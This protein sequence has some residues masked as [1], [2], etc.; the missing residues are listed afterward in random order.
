MAFSETLTNTVING[1]RQLHG[2]EQMS[3]GEPKYWEVGVK[4]QRVRRNAYEKQQMD[5]EAE[6]SK[7]EAYLDIVDLEEIVKDKDNWSYFE[8][9]FKNPMPDE[10]HG[11]KYYLSWLDKFNGLRKIAA[12]RNQEKIYSPEQLEFFQWLN[13]SVISKFDSGLN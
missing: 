10:R 7:K 12:H 9:L 3:S 2:I 13:E 4:S 5:N 11:Q 8:H 1:L 6:R